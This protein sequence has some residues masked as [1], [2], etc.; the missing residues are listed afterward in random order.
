MQESAHLAFPN[1]DRFPSTEQVPCAK[2]IAPILLPFRLLMLRD[3]LLTDIAEFHLLS[4][5]T[6]RLEYRLLT[7][8][9]R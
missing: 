3:A 8:R 7:F 9:T 4:L 1:V 6:P 2:G 5:R